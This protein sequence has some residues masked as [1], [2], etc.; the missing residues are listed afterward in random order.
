M[1]TAFRLDGR[2][3]LVT[4]SSSGLGARMAEALDG[5]GADVVVTGRDVRRLDDRAAS[6]SRSPLV[7]PGDLREAEFRATLIEAVR[8][9]H[10][11][12]D[13][14][15][16]AA[17]TAVA[18]RHRRDRR[19]AALPRLERVQLRHRACAHRRRRLDG[20]L[21]DWRSPAV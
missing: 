6:M 21:T 4:G 12:L 19:A 2:V 11:Q 17:G 20:E 7:V 9:R 3:A 10:G 18:R 1:S 5:A 14:L 16:N 8:D 13:V 15:V